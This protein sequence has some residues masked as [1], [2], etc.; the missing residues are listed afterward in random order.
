MI[1]FRCEFCR[2]TRSV[3][4]SA[5]G[6]SDR[7]ACGNTNVVLKSSIASTI[8]IKEHWTPVERLDDLLVRIAGMLAYQTKNTRSPRNA[9]AAMWANLNEIRSTTDPRSM[10]PE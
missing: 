9:K 2:R 8:C 4:Y 7:C 6:K 1:G 5:A 3:A 10:K